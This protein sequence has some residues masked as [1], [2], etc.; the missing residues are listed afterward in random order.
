MAA[1]VRIPL[2]VRNTTSRSRGEVWSSRRPV[3]P[4][5]AGS[6]PVGTAT[7][8]PQGGPVH[9]TGRSPAPGT[10]GRVAQLAEHTPEK[11]GVRGSTPRSTTS[12]AP[13]RS[14]DPPG[15]SSWSGASLA[16]LSVIC[17][18]GSRPHG[19]S[20]GSR[21]IRHAVELFSCC[22]VANRRQSQRARVGDCTGCTG[23]VA[24]IRGHLGLTAARSPSA[25]ARTHPIPSVRTP[26]TPIGVP[27]GGAA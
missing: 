24:D 5:V 20:E 22:A 27:L 12:K 13:G 8:P 23:Q 16:D 18:H 17:P 4:E 26:A 6:S 21:P 25:T 14:Q 11:R 3:K 19:L 7:G 9:I 2:G 15:A 10:H 1:R